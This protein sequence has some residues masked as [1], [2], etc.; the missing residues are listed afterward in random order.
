MYLCVNDVFLPG[1]C[2]HRLLVQLLVAP[3]QA[4]L[5]SVLLESSTTGLRDSTAPPTACSRYAAQCRQ[6]RGR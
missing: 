2:L 3:L 4:L 6:S 5:L 1:A